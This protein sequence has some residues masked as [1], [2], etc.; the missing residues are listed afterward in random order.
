MTSSYEH[1][2][3]EAMLRRS[4]A[5][6]QGDDQAAGHALVEAG[7]AADAMRATRATRKEQG[8]PTSDD[9]RVP[10]HSVTTAVDASGTRFYVDG[11]LVHREPVRNKP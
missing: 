3:V 9:A 10:M 2:I 8:T 5:L 6:E 11:K 4:E 1:R 7:K